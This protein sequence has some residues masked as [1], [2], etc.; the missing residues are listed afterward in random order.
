MLTRTEILGDIWTRRC[1]K[2]RQEI[3]QAKLPRSLP[4]NEQSMFQNSR[5]DG[6]EDP[7]WNWEVCAAQ[8]H[9]HT[10]TLRPED[11]LVTA[12]ARFWH[13]H[14]AH[15]TTGGRLSRGFTTTSILASPLFLFLPT[16]SPPFPSNILPGF[17]S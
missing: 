12:L 17:R 9:K 7:L 14:I 6:G 16:P 13:P 3:C 10:S 11:R 4:V 15:G 1:F 8:G 5:L 2:V